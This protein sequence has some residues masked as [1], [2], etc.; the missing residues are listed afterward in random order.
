M[1][2]I[3]FIMSF[4]VCLGEASLSSEAL[5]F[6]LDQDFGFNISHKVFPFGL[7][8]RKLI[9]TKKKCEIIVR[10]ES[11]RWIKRAWVIDVCR[12][13][14]HIKEGV[15]SIDVIKKEVPCPNEESDYCES[16]EQIRSIIQNDGLIFAQGEKEDITSDHGKLYCIYAL[17]NK[18]LSGQEILG[19]YQLPTPYRSQG[20]TLKDYY[21]KALPEVLP[22]K[23][24]ESKSAEEEKKEKGKEGASLKSS[25]GG[26]D[27]EGKKGKE[28]GAI[29]EGGTI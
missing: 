8:S 3:I 13:P 19:R 15:Y 26:K 16:F 2:K 27:K 25:H 5:K 6:C 1:K 9:I 4:W 21:L 29:S 18:Y 12:E 17:I 7:F 22:P 14:L 11:Y 23:I 20:Q 10:Y 28:K 24:Q